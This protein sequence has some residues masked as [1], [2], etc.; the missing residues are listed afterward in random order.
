M[1]TSWTRRLAGLLAISSNT[2][3]RLHP[4]TNGRGFSSM[5]KLSNSHDPSTCRFHPVRVSPLV[6]MIIITVAA[7]RH[8]P[9]I[10]AM[11]GDGRVKAAMGHGARK[12]WADIRGLAMVKEGTPY[13]FSV[14]NNTGKFR[15]EPED[16]GMPALPTAAT[17]PTFS[18]G[19]CRKRCCFNVD[20]SGE[21]SGGGTT[22]ASGNTAVPIGGT[23]AP[24]TTSSG[25]GGNGGGAGYQSVAV[26]LADG[27]G[28]RRRQDHVRPGEFL[29]RPSA[30]S[31]RALTGRGH[32]GRFSNHHGGP[33][34]MIR[35]LTPPR[36]SEPRP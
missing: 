16:P 32:V 30:C 10:H 6:M 4:R 26:Y 17:S 21:T 9:V 15:I 25:G 27:T 5:L 2:D 11:M 7:V 34:M 14:I 23:A 31:R 29:P 36:S 3:V 12:R 1:S 19:N 33:T 8:G 35:R 13:K 18:R 28:A 20:T 24:S 22:T